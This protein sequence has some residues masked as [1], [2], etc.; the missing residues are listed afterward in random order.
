MPVGF[1]GDVVPYA[2]RHATA[3]WMA[4]PG[5]R[6]REIAQL[7]GHGDARTVEKHCAKGHPDFRKCSMNAIEASLAPALSHPRRK[8]GDVLALARSLKRMVGATGF[9]PVTPTMST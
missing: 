6:L 2:L 3:I 8:K 4:Q 9:E 5:V 7:P 1:G